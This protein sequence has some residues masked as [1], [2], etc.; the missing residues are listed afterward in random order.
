[1][2]H[3]QLSLGKRGTPIAPPKLLAAILTLPVLEGFARR[4]EASFAGPWG[5]QTFCS[6][7]VWLVQHLAA[8]CPR[9]PGRL[10]G[11]GGQRRKAT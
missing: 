3:C 9:K 7:S 8:W 6:L 4:K 11:S 2:P 10:F 1:M 5:G